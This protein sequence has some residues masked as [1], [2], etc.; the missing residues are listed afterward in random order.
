MQDEE[1]LEV[2]RLAVAGDDAVGGRGN[3]RVRGVLDR[4]G[5]GEH[6][7]LVHRDLAA[8]GQ[9]RGTL[10]FQRDG[11]VCGERVAF[12]DVPGGVGAGHGVEPEAGAR[13]RGPAVERIV[14]VVAADGREDLDDGG[15]GVHID[16]V[17][18]EPQVIQPP[19]GER[20]GAFDPGRVDL[21]A[22]G[23]GR[24]GGAAGLGAG[25]KVAAA[26]IGSGARGRGNAVAGLGRRAFAERFLFLG[27]LLR[28]REQNKPDQD[29]HEAECG[30]EQEVLVLTVHERGVPFLSHQPAFNS[31]DTQRSSG[32]P[33]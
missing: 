33:M 17:V 24:G 18:L 25:G 7:V 1:V 3:R 9:A 23:L 31:S 19:A 13:T 21:Q 15:L 14:G 28:R 16:V 11:A 8:E 29:H 22:G 10:P 6:V 12:G 5:D 30:G 2:L 26:G 20:D 32:F 27:R 4:L